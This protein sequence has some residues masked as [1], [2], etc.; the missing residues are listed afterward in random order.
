[1]YSFF[2]I[3]YRVTIGLLLILAAVLL[4]LGYLA[5]D[6]RKDEVLENLRSKGE[7]IASLVAFS[8]GEAVLKFQNYRLEELAQSACFAPGIVS[9]SIYNQNGQLY[10]EF[11]N[12]ESSGSSKNILYTEKRILKDGEYLGYVKVGVL[13]G[14]GSE[15]VE[16]FLHF[17]L[18][19]FIA[20][21][22]IGGL[23][24]S[25][26]LSRAFVSPVIRLA[27]QAAGIS[28]GDFEEFDD[29]GRSDEVG[30][31]ARSLNLL[32]R[33]FSL[34]NS[35]LER[36]VAERTED[37]TEANRKLCAEVEER[38][39]VESN[40]SSA[41]EELS[42]TVQEL[43]KSKEKAEK[44]SRFKSEFLAM[45]S[46]E[47]RTPMNAI[48][49]MGDLLL[50]TE[51]DP[52]Q[53]GYVE[54]FRGS[55][56]LL[57]KIINDILD[58]VQIES[59]QIELVP[60]PF[61]PSRDVQS[62]CKS[63]AHSAHA[64]DIE[65]ICDVDQD[66]PAQVVGDPVRVRQILMNIV[67][68]AVKFTSS[69]EVDVRLSLEESGDDFDRLLFT[70]RDTGVGI[71]EGERGNIFESFVQA[72]GSTSREFGGIGLGLA[73]A[74]RLAVLMDGEI[75]F[76]SKRGKG[77]IFYFSI[78]FKKSVYEPAKSVADFS[79]TKV[80]LIDDNH[81]VRE[82]LSRRLQA[83]GV[84]PVVA[85]D[86]GEGLKYLEVAADRRDHFDLVVL[87]STMPD[88]LGVDFLSKAQQ[89]RLL[90]GLVAIMFSAGCTED[91]RRN[92]RMFG[93]DY[94]LIK[95]VFDADLIRCLAA[96]GETEKQQQEKT[97]K[98]M[99]ILLVEDNKD[100]RKILDLFIADTGAEVTTAVD[101]LR[102]VQLFS[103]NDYDLVFMDLELPV[104]GGLEAVGRMR[105]FEK[106][107]D[108][109]RTMII[110]LAAHAFSDH[111]ERSRS[112]GC[113]GFIS[114]PVKWDTIRS[115]VSAVSRGTELPEEIKIME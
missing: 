20:I 78:P 26:F 25:F 61:D 99:N 10:S 110:A 97:G 36:K 91:E 33:K 55:G 41:L 15:N 100:H 2:R 6:F 81:T 21:A 39:R 29:E 48:L 42:F 43:E 71:P 89:K 49:G 51:L 96:T 65:V 60:V 95:P 24:V 5:T 76:D 103:D 16:Y 68:N 19:A 84:E 1:M 88:M 35:D 90:T 94:T 45:I 75:W 59:G 12:L 7:G 54:I 105:E 57:L 22:V 44:A 114:K 63:V 14:G 101:G 69:G 92:A 74:S 109:H 73:A 77:S 11:S 9:C 53:M 87:D 79:G 31:L 115:T 106:S 18:P 13:K 27:K 23:C 8:S 67:S 4:P 50:E 56:E 102:A 3:R 47:I 70:V 30:D 32:S 82:V 113:D 80:L 46:H 107:G 108:R 62:V 66:V 86:G 93:A 112:V 28:Q 34:M 85:I 104:M 72:D 40:L 64:R 111:R 83:F 17:L 52:E 38:V 98:G 58:F 37:L